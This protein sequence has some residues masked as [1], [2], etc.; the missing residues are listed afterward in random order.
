MEHKSEQIRGFYAVVD[1]PVGR[2]NPCAR[3]VQLR[4]KQAV[5]AELVTVARRLREQSR[6]TLLIVN[7]RI[8]V[9]LAVGADGVHLG[10][11]DLAI[12]DA[13]RIP[14][15]DQLLIGISTHNLEQVSAAVAGGANY[16][17]YGPVFATSTKHNPDPVQGLEA[18]AAA[19]T[20]ASAS[21]GRRYRR[22]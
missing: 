22:H 9:A 16:L 12:E 15:A 10:Q 11:D 20:R 5:T 4:L 19:V 7:D 21:T 2:A 8:D 6:D 3:I 17:G 14:G 1:T 13:R 18:L